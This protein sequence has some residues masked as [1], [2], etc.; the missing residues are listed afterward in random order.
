MLAMSFLGGKDRFHPFKI[1]ANI[2]DKLLLRPDRA[3]STDTSP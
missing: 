2:P 1:A 3:L